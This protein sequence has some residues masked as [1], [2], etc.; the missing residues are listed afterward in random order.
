MN[1]P[2]LKLA[3]LDDLLAL[4][5]EARVELID[6]QLVPKAEANARHGKAQRTV[7][8]AIGGPFDDGDNGG[9]GGWWILTETRI[10]LGQEVY[11]PDIAGWRRERLP[12]PAEQTPVVV[13]PDWCC[14][15]LS[16]GPTNIRRD[17]VTKRTAYAR[18]G[19][20]Y[21]WLVDPEARVLEALE[22]DGGGWREC[23]AWDDTAH[24]A[25]IVPF[26]EIALDVGRFFFPIP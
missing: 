6:G 9:P 26:E 18:A 17:R 19:V 4:D 22:L 16:P 3:T 8:T 7:A 13:I 20:R 15:V 23:G 10:Q 21:Y 24:D 5:A 1:T 11:R 25:R 2:A 14:E 12:N